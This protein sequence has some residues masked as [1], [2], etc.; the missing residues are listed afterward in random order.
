MNLYTNEVDVLI[1]FYIKNYILVKDGSGRRRAIRE[2]DGVGNKTKSC[3][4]THC[5]VS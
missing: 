1:Y 5:F 2:R 3:M 4:K